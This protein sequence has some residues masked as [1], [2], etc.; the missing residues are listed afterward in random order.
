MPAKSKSPE[1]AQRKVWKEELKQL[2]S[3][4]RK[5]TRDYEHELKR[6]KGE[7][8]KAEKALLNFKKRADK[9]VAR[10]RAKVDSRRSVL[11]GRLGL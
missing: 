5:V 4:T 1:A 10:E 3:V 11:R 2:D 6:L 9:T 8:S 7:I